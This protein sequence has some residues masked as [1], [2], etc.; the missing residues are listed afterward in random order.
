[1]CS[2]FFYKAPK[3][4]SKLGW[5]FITEKTKKKKK[6]SLRR[7]L[8]PKEMGMEIYSTDTPTWALLISRRE[9]ESFM[10]KKTTL[11]N[12]LGI[13]LNF[14]YALS[15][16]DC[17]FWLHLFL[18]FWSGTVVPSYR[19]FLLFVWASFWRGF[20]WHNENHPLYCTPASRFHKIPEKK[21]KKSNI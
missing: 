8:T 7:R 4:R 13:F 16:K 2:E 21:W 15:C 14:Y 12:S 9:K 3:R 6:T 18:I 1:M 17:V 10:E 19:I 5:S 20:S 11:S